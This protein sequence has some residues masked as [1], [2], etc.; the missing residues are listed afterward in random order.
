MIQTEKASSEMKCSDSQKRSVTFSTVEVREYPMILGDNPAVSGGPPVTI[1][2]IPLSRKLFE[3]EKHIRMTPEPR[4]KSFQMIMP[5]YHRELLLK[6]SG[7]TKNELLEA[8]RQID[9]IR[10]QRLATIT[11]LHRM[12]CMDKIS[13]IMKSKATMAFCRR[14][15]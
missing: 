4:R 10:A 8:K 7:Y 6:N 3:I 12:E 2:W 15:S 13:E 9:C 5:I 1:D 11:R 14:K